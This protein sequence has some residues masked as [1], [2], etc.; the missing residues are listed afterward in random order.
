MG[1]RSRYRAT[2]TRTA[3]SKGKHDMAA[4]RYTN[5]PRRVIDR[6]AVA[7]S[8]REL[9]KLFG[10]RPPENDKSHGEVALVGAA[11]SELQAEDTRFLGGAQ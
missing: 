10:K 5:T 3:A 2:C 8:L 11:D 4:Q 1:E 9:E 6:A 7:K